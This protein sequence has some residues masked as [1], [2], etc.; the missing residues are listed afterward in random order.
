M[1]L[2]LSD[3]AIA[4]EEDQSQEEWIVKTTIRGKLVK[5]DYET[6]VPKMERLIEEYGRIRLLVKLIDFHGWRRKLGK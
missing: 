2:F 5:K 6:F 1:T 3:I 4:A